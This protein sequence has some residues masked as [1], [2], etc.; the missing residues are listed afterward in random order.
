M[1]NDY[2]RLVTGE[3]KNLTGMLFLIGTL[4]GF[5]YHTK[6]IEMDEPH[7]FIL[8]IGIITFSMFLSRI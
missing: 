2:S 6:K 7:T 8:L 3:N 4:M 1:R 5:F